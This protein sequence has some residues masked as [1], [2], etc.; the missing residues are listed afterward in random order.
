MTTATKK[1]IIGGTFDQAAARFVDVWDKALR[2][3][4]IEAQDIITVVS[5]SQLSSVMTD[6]RHELLRHLHAHPTSSI[7]GLAR[8]LGREY[9]RVH[10]D[11][12]ALVD[13]GLIDKDGRMLK[14][15]YS[16]IESEIAV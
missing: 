10:A 7:R 8:E 6:K 13:A 2:G 12:T 1:I 4:E 9:K 11:V 14:V 3:D 5:W 15:E 16:R